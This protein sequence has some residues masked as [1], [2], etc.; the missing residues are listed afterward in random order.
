MRW[1]GLVT[2]T[3]KTLNDS[4]NKVRRENGEK[5]LRWIWIEKGLIPHYV[6]EEQQNIQEKK[7]PTA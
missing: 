5:H 3:W 2:L 4:I 6:E 1:T 7:N